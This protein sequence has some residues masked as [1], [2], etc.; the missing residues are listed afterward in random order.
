MAP[1][2]KSKAKIDLLNWTVVFMSFN[3]SW[4]VETEK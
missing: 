3:P 2:S 4:V 1:D